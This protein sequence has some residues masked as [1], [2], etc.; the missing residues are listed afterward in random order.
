MCILCVIQ[1]WSRRIAT[2]LPWLVIPLI[3]LW[4]LSQLLPP[5]FRFEITSPRLACLLVLLVTLFWYEVLMPQLSAWRVRRNDRL[6]ERKRF[7]A[8]ERQKLRKTATRRCR[9]CLTAYRDQNP[10]GSKFMC[11]YCGHISKRPVL[12]LPVS[13]GMGNSGI[14]KDLVGKGGKILNGKNWSDNGWICGQDWLENGNWVVGP[15]AG[16]SNRKR[17][18]I[19]VGLFGGDDDHCLAEKS[20]SR[21]FIFA[22]KIL[23][24][25]LLSIMWI[26]RKIFRVSSS[27]DDTSSDSER[28]GMLDNQ[29]ENGGNGQESRG[30]KA[31]R[32]AEEKRHARLEKEL[33]EEEERKQREEVAR[34]VEEQRRLRDEKLEAEKDRSKGSPRAKERDSRKESERKHQERRKEKDRGSSKSNSDVEELEK[35]VGKESD[36]NKRSDSDRRDQQRSTPESMKAHGTELGHGF[37]GAA[38]GSHNRGNAGTRYLDRMK[39]TFFSSSRAFT[40][41]GFFGKNTNMPIV[42]RELK[43]SPLL[44]N[45]QTVAYRKETVQPDQASGRPTVHVD[46]KGSNRPVLIEHQPST[47]P[48]KSWQQLFARSPPVS[49]PSNTNVISR[50]TGNHKAEVQN[51]PFS[52]N[53]PPTKSVDNPIDFGLQSPFSLPSFPFESSTSSTVLPL[54][55]EPIQPKRADKQHQ[56]LL[57]ET[58]IFEDP[59][60]VPDP[61]SLLGPVSES[62]DS[63]QLD[64]GFVDTGMEKPCAVKTKSAHSKVTKPSPIESPLSRSRVSEDSS[65]GLNGN[66]T[67]Q[68]WNSSPL[69][70]DGLGLVGGPINWHLHPEMNLLN[71]EDNMRHVPHKT[72]ASLFK[73]DEQ[74]SSG[75]HP[76]QHVLFGNS[77]N[78]GIINTSGPPIS[79]GPWL[80]RTLF[81]QTSD[82]QA[83]MKPN[84]EMLQNGL[85]YGNT[86]GP[87]A[88]HQF[89][90]PA[91][92]CWTR[93]DWTVAGSRENVGSSP[94]NRPHIGG[95][96]S[97]PDVQSLWSYE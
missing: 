7:E 61:I 73:K 74:T 25:F 97:P 5:A 52:G 82:N 43:P 50:P 49:A 62:L 76:P 96:Y 60:Y 41:G 10:G 11:S 38:A 42:L 20:Y 94:T 22:C 19:G 68:M 93:K 84:G 9:N 92:S 24:A 79:D 67:W 4:A 45:A 58:E 28:R 35:R 54:S 77:Q 44:E 29:S 46:D 90:V 16:K 78:G 51:T 69:V 21:V 66:G 8:I 71:K 36:N 72:M 48:K 57:E 55:S 59:C 23:T 64:L 80:P 91:S 70:Q 32:K 95:L 27:S 63:F 3:G 12:D 87:P 75:P 40:R 17:N 18:G 39:G 31:R 47:A 1:K 26:W 37:K 34:L 85:I 65:N 30:E 86:S 13:P 33:L 83:A 15:F 53:P 6:R 88:N 89:D 2:M 14:L 56:F 81:G